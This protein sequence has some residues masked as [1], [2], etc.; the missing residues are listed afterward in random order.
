MLVKHLF[1]LEQAQLVI[2]PSILTNRDHCSR[3]QSP[4]L[5]LG[6]LV[7]LALK[8][9]YQWQALAASINPFNYSNL[10]LIPRLYKLRTKALFRPSNYFYDCN[11]SY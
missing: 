6:S 10:F 2:G 7:I 5:I 11:N 1:K 3:R 4:N 9:E 8:N